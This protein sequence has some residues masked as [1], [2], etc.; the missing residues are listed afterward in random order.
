MTADDIAQQRAQVVGDVLGERA[1]A[2]MSGV[3][4]GDD[5]ALERQRL[6]PRAVNAMRLSGVAHSAASRP[7]TPAG[8]VGLEQRPQRKQVIG[9]AS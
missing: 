6:G 4:A 8:A 2:G 7:G 5:R 3:G 1:R 9:H